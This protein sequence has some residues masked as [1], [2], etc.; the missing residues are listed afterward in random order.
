MSSLAIQ[1]TAVEEI[2]R[3]R[4]HSF[5]DA[6]HTLQGLFRRKDPDSA[7]HGGRVAAYATAIARECELPLPEIGHLRL[8]AELHDI[9]KIAVPDALLCQPGPL[10]LEQRRRVLQHTILGEEILRPLLRHH[11]TALEIVRW[12][13]ERLDGSGYPDGLVGAAI[14]IG[15]RI[16]AVA[17]AF[18]AMTSDRP[19]RA[20]LDWTE[21]LCELERQ[22]G[23]LFDR[24]CVRA[25]VNWTLRAD[26]TRR[27]PTLRRT[28]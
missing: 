22:A 11:P 3:P 25:L 28:P 21:A 1:P 16:V 20:S 26:P 19:Y 4:G 18:D 2:L 15:V 7:S 24:A 10:S 12:H 13:H 5:A 9:G 14:P 17:D 27:R 6:V 8:G 23:T